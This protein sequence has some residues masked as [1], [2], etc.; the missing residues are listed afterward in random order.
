MNR[1][2]DFIDF[3]SSMMGMS[4]E[5]YTA[6][7]LSENRGTKTFE[8]FSINEEDEKSRSDGFVPAKIRRDFED[9]NAGTEIAIDALDYSKAGK[10]DL[11]ASYLESSDEMIRIPKFLIELEDGEGI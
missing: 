8:Q 1:I 9:F 7:Y 3:H 2:T 4:R 5:E 10:D 11:V 6:Y